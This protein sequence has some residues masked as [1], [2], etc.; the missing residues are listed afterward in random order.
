[1]VVR[2]S[3]RPAAS[4]AALRANPIGLHKIRADT[5]PAA[6]M[7]R[8]HLRTLQAL[9]AHPLQ[10][11]VRGSQVEALLL[12]LGAELTPLSGK[13]LQIRLPGGE[14]TWI[15]AACGIRHPDLDPEAMLRLRRFLRQAGITPEHPQAEEPGPRGDQARRLVLHL[16]RRSTDVYLLEGEAVEH[17]QLKPHGLWGGDQNLSH[18][19]ERDLPGQRA[20]LDH[21]YLNRITAAIAAADAVLLVGH[22]TGES[23]LR[24][25]LVHHLKQQHP[26]LLERL[27]GVVE[28]DDS[29]IS[30][31]AL[32]ALAR[33]HFGNQ[34]H[35]RVLVIPGQE[36]REPGS[37]SSH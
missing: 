8:Q 3:A 24:Q 10:H 31:G 21:D 6:A 19:H 34:P 13:R 25:L 28:V 5:Q 1:M 29:A 15:E 22:G 9:Y 30:E 27:V 37:T 18:R 16:S 20:P 35:R 2:L 11:G 7:Q 26:E 33:E 32:L 17:G 36:V 14:E 23:D 12:S 4:C